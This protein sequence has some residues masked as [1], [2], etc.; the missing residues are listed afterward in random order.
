VR[1]AVRDRG[2]GIS[3]EDV[4]RLFAPFQRLATHPTAGE[5]S[6]GLGL[7]IAQ[8]IARQHGGVIQVQSQPGEGSTFTLELPV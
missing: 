4:P 6:H 8:E 2:A 5:S 7:S 3:P 1:L